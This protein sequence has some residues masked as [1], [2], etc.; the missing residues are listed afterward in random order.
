MVELDLRATADRQ[1]VV[2]HDPDVDRVTD[3]SGPIAAL[4]LAQVRALDAAH[5]YRPDRG[6][7]DPGEDDGSFPLRGR[8]GPD[9]RIPTLGEL[10]DALP[11]VSL[12][13]D[14]K[15]GPPDAP[16]LPGRVAALL[17]AH[18]RVDDVIVGSFDQGRLD[19]FRSLAPG[20][21]TSATQDE[22]VAFF[23]GG[24]APDV[25]GFRAF[26]VPAS[27]GGIEVVTADFVHRAHRAGAEVHVWT[28]D[29]PAEMRRLADLGVDGII[30]DVPSVGLDALRAG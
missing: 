10:L 15:A 9:L 12:V 6:T 19:A 16:W 28:V 4:T 23:S 8:R 5:R 24:P 17:R 27:F 13:M 7:V 30:T 1:V 14:L 22:V 26:Q 25:G 21:A 20:V 11:T 2:L 29:E 18:G 3:G